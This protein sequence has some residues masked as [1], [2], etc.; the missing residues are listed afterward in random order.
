MEDKAIFLSEPLLKIFRQMNCLRAGI[1]AM[2]DDSLS[3]DKERTFFFFYPNLFL[4]DEID[5]SRD[6]N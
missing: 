3:I 5:C 1:I 4:N 2:E 6:L